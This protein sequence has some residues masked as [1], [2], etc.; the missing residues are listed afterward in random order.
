MPFLFNLRILLYTLICD[1]SAPSATLAVS[2]PS[3]YLQ[4]ED[5]PTADRRG[6]ECA[7]GAG[8]FLCAI[9][10]RASVWPET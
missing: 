5:A 1:D 3:E 6:R 2:M 9:W 7:Q 8:G 4:A 10:E